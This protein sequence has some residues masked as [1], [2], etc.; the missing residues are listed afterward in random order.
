MSGSPGGPVRR[1]A[2]AAGQ[3][4][5]PRSSL[6]DRLWRLPLGAHAAVLALLLLV[7]APF[8]F[9]DATFTADEGAYA[10]QVRA[11]ESDSW[12]YDYRAE[13]IDPTGEWLPLLNG[14]R[15]SDAW[16]AYVKHP[17]F[18]AALRA[19]TNLIGETAGLHVLGLIGAVLV[20]V[21]AWLLAAELEPR[22]SRPAFWIAAAS[23][24]AVNAYIIWAHAPAAALAG[25]AAVAALRLKRTGA[26]GDLAALLASLSAGVLLRSEGLLLAG[27]MA[28][29]IA[30]VGIPGRSWR[31]RFGVPA[32]CLAVT[33]ATAALEDR[34]IRSIVGQGA[35]GTRGITGSAASEPGGG[36]LDW[37]SGRLRGA[38]NSLL[39]GAHLDA[40]DSALVLVALVL[41]LLSLAA[42]RRRRPGWERDVSVAL[43]AATV[44]YVA[45]GVTGIDQSITGLVAAWPLVLFALAA[46]V[47]R[48][49]ARRLLVVICFVMSGAVLLTQYRIGGGFEWGGR[50]FLLLLAP[51]AVLAALGI[52][53]VVHRA[54]SAGR[55]MARL[56]VALAVVPVATG[57]VVLRTTRPLLDDVVK[58][59]S[60]TGPRLVLTHS[61]ALPPAA[62]RTYPE[63]GWMRAA[64]ETTAATAARLRDRGVRQLLVVVPQS[65]AEQ[66]Q[67]L[68]PG[69]VDLSGP[70]ARR[71]G[72]R[73]L[74][75]P[76]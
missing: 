76:G 15:G 59:V 61:P 49:H 4:A 14:T 9:L 68:I 7:A 38:W 39:R 17:A 37:A 35:A 66:V 75:L 56:C 27:A 34:W 71:L 60:A 74:R 40:Q 32:A 23:P 2:E 62:W 58:E 24:V 11:L 26:A 67:E 28:V 3:P 51:L 55:V 19:A 42:W 6:A 41:I 33:A 46:P 54:G 63:V 31:V 10:L 1:L 16:Y 29:A 30:A 43:A 8:L 25:I 20:A 5:P 48:C 18:P 47:G 13:D 57:L 53:E 73:I 12:A 70:G 45:R 52:R 22:V 36:W 65:T 72:W 69:A 50:F 21:A 64:E 44:L